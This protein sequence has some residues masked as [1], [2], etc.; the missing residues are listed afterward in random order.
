[1]KR[2]LSE[3]LENG[4]VSTTDAAKFLGVNEITVRRECDA[5][6][7]PSTRIR[8]RRT[9]PIKALVAYRDAR[10]VGAAR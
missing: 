10:T 8:G 7:L 9:I 6:H 5:L 2:D 1:V 4:N 3:L